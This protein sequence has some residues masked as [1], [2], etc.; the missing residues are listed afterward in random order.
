[1]KLSALTCSEQ[2]EKHFQMCHMRGGMEGDE[3]GVGGG[4]LFCLPLLC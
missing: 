1:M 3:D 2:V 4:G